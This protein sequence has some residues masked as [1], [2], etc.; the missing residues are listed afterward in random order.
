MSEVKH[1]KIKK[2][3]AINMTRAS[4]AWDNII[5]SN[6]HAVGSQKER[7]HMREKEKKE[8]KKINDG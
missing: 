6:I 4:V 8:R 3:I 2:K 1:R 7:V 5:Q